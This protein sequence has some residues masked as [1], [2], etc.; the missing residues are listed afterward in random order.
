MCDLLHKF[1]L[2]NEYWS[3]MGRHGG[4]PLREQRTSSR[5][6][7]IREKCG[8]ERSK[9]ICG[10]RTQPLGELGHVQP[11]IVSVAAADRRANGGV[12]RCRLTVHRRTPI[13][14][15]LKMSERRRLKT[16]ARRTRCR[17]R[18]R[19]R[20]RCS[21]SRPVPQTWFRNRYNDTRRSAYGNL[22][23]SLH[24]LMM[25]PEMG[26]FCCFILPTARYVDAAEALLRSF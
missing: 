6:P 26:S 23:S 18:N 15:W 25:G 17:S 12:K 1:G 10:R 9:G 22:D 21:G 5:I 13:E 20:A 11:R 3:V 2:N 19:R 8:F 7:E 24:S 16:G 14:S 4:R